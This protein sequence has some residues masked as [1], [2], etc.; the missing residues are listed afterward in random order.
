MGL[1]TI[2]KGLKDALFFYNK[3]ADVTVTDLKTENELQNSVKK[4]KKYPKIKLHLG[5][6]IESDFID[7]D[8]IVRNPAVPK[9]SVFLEIARKNDK[10]IVM[11]DS[12]AVSLTSA[13]I[14]GITGTRGKTTTST[15]IYNILKKAGFDAYLSGNIKGTAS[16]SLLDKLNKS[17]HLN[18]CGDKNSYLVLEL[19]SW[20][21]QGFCFKKI[22]PN[23][24]VI[25]NIYPDHL[26]RYESMKEYIDDKKCIYKFQTKDD[27]LFLSN[28][29]E[30]KYF[31]E[32]KYEAQSNIIYFSKEDAKDYTTQLLGEHNLENIAAARIIALHLGIDEDLIKAVVKDFTSIEFRLQKIREING[33]TFIND[34]ASTAPIAGIKALDSFNNDILLIAGGAS[35]NLPLYDWG[36]AIVQKCKKVALLQGNDTFKLKEIIEKLNKDLI[37]GIFNN[38]EPAVKALYKEAKQGDIILLSPGSASF[39]MFQ[40]EF[41]RGEQFN[42]IVNSLIE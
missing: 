38:L 13:K 35:K 15:L 29:I 25:I 31:N 2:G 27:F 21:L 5:K 39:G 12:L 33:I 36:K 8:I 34:S 28:N 19:S 37:L 7:N 17:S 9:D 26:N 30:D 22:S 4:F 41:D 1:G 16:L 42:I 32:F 10:K 11:D 20:Q 23:Y 14:I 40:N 18:K 24:S 3:G 6:H